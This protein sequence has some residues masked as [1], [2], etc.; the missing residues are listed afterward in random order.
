MSYS[1]LKSLESTHT[2]NP[3]YSEQGWE[4]RMWDQVLEANLGYIGKSYF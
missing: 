1:C 3:S 4:L 2:W